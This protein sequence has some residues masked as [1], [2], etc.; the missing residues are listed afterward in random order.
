M[1]ISFQVISTKG[2]HFLFFTESLTLS[3]HVLCCASDNL[4]LGLKSSMSKMV[5]VNTVL[6]KKFVTV[7]DKFSSGIQVDRLCTSCSAVIA[8]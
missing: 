7:F 3:V 2:K 8:V 6:T 5:I 4:D 1:S